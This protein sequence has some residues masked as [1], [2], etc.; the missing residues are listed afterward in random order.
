MH[1]AI[2]LEQ[3]EI[4]SLNIKKNVAHIRTLQFYL[5]H[6]LK[7]KKIHTVVEFD[8]KRYQN[9]TLN[10]T[11]RKESMLGMVLKRIYSS[12][13]NAVF[14]KTMEDK[15]KHLDFEIV[16]DEKRFMKCVNNPSFK[17]SHFIN[18][19]LVGVEKL[20]PKLKLGMS[21]LD[22]R[23]QHMYRFFYDVMTP[24]YGENIRVVYTDTESFVFHTQTDDIYRDLKEM[25]KWTSVDMTKTISAMMQVRRR[26]WVNLRMNAKE[27]K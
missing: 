10:L 21:I 16:N 24:K 5:K 2:E 27:N 26:C 8:K 20:K 6:G 15:R 7:L 25:M 1:R 3:K 19:N 4:L 23:K 22:L 12:Y 14:G 18:E 17:H 9:L 11:Q 13:E